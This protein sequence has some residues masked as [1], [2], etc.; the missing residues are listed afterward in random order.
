MN[1]DL[2]FDDG[3][4][5]GDVKYRHL[6]TDWSRSDL[7]QVVAFATAFHAPKCG[8]FAFKKQEAAELPRA[9]PVGSVRAT[10]FGWL[11]SASSEPAES[12]ASLIRETRAWLC[13]AS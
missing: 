4:A 7:N 10:S 1:P 8:L 12:A 13:M 11:A 5:V 3:A 2:V 6:A 9:V